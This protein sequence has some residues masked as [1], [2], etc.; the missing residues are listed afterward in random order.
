[1]QIVLSDFQDQLVRGLTHRMNN[2]LSLFHGYLGMLMDG[3][4]LDPAAR[5]GLQKIKAGAQSAT[6]L[7][8]R[9]NGLVRPTS[10]VWRESS[11]ADLLRQMRP[12]F[13]SFCG[14]KVS[15]HIECAADLPHVWVDASRVRMALLELVR[16]ACEAAKSR[17]QIRVT[18]SE[19]RVQ[20]ELFQTTTEQPEHWLTVSITDDGPGIPPERG[21]HIYEPFYTTK[22]AH[23]STGLGL[24]VAMGCAQQLSGHLRHHSHPGETTFDLVL[25]SRAA[26]ELSAVA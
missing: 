25:P 12:T 3:K 9:T 14:A 21:E 4:D 15:I 8:E 13:E 11:L 18:A 19:G 7:M 16:N 1:M 2:I 26:E 22:R 24:T 17:V 10:R 20:G 23:N 5:E 6:E